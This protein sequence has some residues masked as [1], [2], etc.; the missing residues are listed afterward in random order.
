MDFV[1]TSCF[2]LICSYGVSLKIESKE[3]FDWPPFKELI[4]VWH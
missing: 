3:S 1:K 2:I 4:K